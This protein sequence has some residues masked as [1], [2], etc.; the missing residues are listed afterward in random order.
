MSRNVG[1]VRSVC[2]VR[3]LSIKGKQHG[4]FCSST[5]KEETAKATGNSRNN[6]IS[7]TS[8]EYHENSWN[9]K[10]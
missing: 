5:N 4:S 6:K 1:C 9:L 10:M 8:E 3:D 2:P 7:K